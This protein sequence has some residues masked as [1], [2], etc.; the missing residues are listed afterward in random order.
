MIMCNVYVFVKK[1][2]ALRTSP[3]EFG[4]RVK[5]LA[6][7]IVWFSGCLCLL[8]HTQRLRSKRHKQIAYSLN[9]ARAKVFPHKP[10]HTQTHNS[11]ECPLCKQPVDAS[12]KV[13]DS[14]KR[15]V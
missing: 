3:L 4:R 11:D 6:G 12:I 15:K 7:M 14:Y 5:I 1:I 2:D 10:I 8:L 13:P 9:R